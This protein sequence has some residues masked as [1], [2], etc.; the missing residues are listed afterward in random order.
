VRSTTVSSPSKP[1]LPP[2]P[3]ERE[4]SKF[5]SKLE[6]SS[7]PIN[8][9][10][11]FESPPLPPKTQL[12]SETDHHDVSSPQMNDPL[13]AGPHAPI[14][15]IQEEPEIARSNN[16]G[17][18]IRIVNDLTT[19]DDA[20]LALAMS[21]LFKNEKAIAEEQERLDLEFARKLQAEED[22][23]VNPPQGQHS[24]AA[25]SLPMPFPTPSQPPPAYSSTSVAG[26]QASTSS[27]GGQT[28]STYVPQEHRRFSMDMPTPHDISSS[29][30]HSL[31]SVPSSQR[32]SQV[33]SQSIS[34]DPKN[35]SQLTPATELRRIQTASSVTDDTSSH[36]QSDSSHTS[37]TSGMHSRIDPELLRAVCEFGHQ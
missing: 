37:T 14:G 21:D 24:P 18:R 36:L 1:V 19:V 26:P 5:Y 30:A 9:T 23:V 10:L 31:R 28:R 4:L 20:S 2:R 11:P 17:S 6:S 22:H 32:N 25:E 15:T 33:H 35:A 27:S 12:P 13:A 16:T 3:P 8:P 34:P 7:P 29:L